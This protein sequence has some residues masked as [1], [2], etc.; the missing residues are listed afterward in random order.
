MEWM[1]RLKNVTQIS[2]G[3]A[4]QTTGKVTGDR[5]LESEGVSDQRLG[6]LRQAGEKVRD[7]FK[8]R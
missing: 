8:K 4:K 1:N 6:N 3:K 7:A 2:R 5:D